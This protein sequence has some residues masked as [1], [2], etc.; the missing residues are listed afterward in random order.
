[1]ISLTEVKNRLRFSLLT[2]QALQW[3]E[4]T[5]EQGSVV[6]HNLEAFTA[7]FQKYLSRQPILSPI[8]DQLFHLKQGASVIDNASC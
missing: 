7:Y 4:A 6:T 3:A 5:W 1:M 8:L 2:G